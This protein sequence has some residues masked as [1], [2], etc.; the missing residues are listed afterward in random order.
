MRLVSDRGIVAVIQNWSSTL[1]PASF[2][3][4]GI[5]FYQYCNL[6]SPTTGEFIGVQYWDRRSV[7]YL[8]LMA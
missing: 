1:W 5:K 3:H 2:V 4:N 6:F 7:R 8:N